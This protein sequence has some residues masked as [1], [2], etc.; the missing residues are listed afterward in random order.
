MKKRILINGRFSSHHFAIRN[1]IY[2]VAR[3]VSS[4]DD[5]ECFIV[6][7]RDSEIEDFKKLPL[8]II[9]NDFP[10]DSGLKNH[11][12]TMFKLPTILKNKNIDIVVYPQICI[13]LRNPCKS[14]LY[15]HDLIEYK[16][17]SQNWKK[18]LFRKISY[19][20]ICKKADKI[21]AVSENTKKDL[22][23]LLKVPYDKI[24][25]AYDGKDTSLVPLDKNVARKYIEKTYGISNYI[26]YIGYLTHPQKNLIYLISEFEN[27]SQKYPGYTLVFAGPKGKDADLILE[28]AQKANINF[29]YIGKVPYDDLASLYS[30]CQ[31]FVF[32]SLYEGF[33]MPV[34]EAMSCG[35]PVITSNTSSLPEIMGDTTWTIDPNEKGA[36]EKAL[37]N[38]NNSN[39]KQIEE[40]NKRR[41]SFFSW[42]NHGKIL[43]NEI[44]KLFK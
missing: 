16:V 6:L 5:C 42:D 26:F 24:I 1:V 15:M 27:F 34:L 22:N 14:I 9:Y 37:E 31:W 18:M 12:Y 35:A 2:N 4:R 44:S 25:V 17:N 30:A 7:N 23:E 36:L 3:Q 43:N 21:I 28:T 20:Y 29:K 32:P 33:G 19:P 40:T 39:R 38:M 10:S 13:F 8:T 41:S 11:I